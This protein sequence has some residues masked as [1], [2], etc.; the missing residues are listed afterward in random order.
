MVSLFSSVQYFLIAKNIIERFSS[1]EELVTAG[2]YTAFDGPVVSFD[3]D[4]PLFLFGGVN[5]EAQ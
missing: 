1:H 5:T 2:G 4:T 3:I